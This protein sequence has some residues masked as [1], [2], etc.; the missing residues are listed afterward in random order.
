ME[1]LTIDFSNVPEEEWGEVADIV[2]G[3]T[4]AI[5]HYSNLRVTVEDDFGTETLDLKL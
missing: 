3:F 4:T 5:A 1:K 2:K